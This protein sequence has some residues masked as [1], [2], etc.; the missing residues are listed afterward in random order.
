VHG[1]THTC[2]HKKGQLDADILGERTKLISFGEE[3]INYFP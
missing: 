3:I 2:T 1:Y